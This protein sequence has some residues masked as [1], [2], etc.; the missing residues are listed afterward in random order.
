[1]THIDTIAFFLASNTMIRTLFLW[2]FC[3]TSLLAQSIAVPVGDSTVM[4]NYHPGKGPMYV[5]LHENETTALLAIKKIAPVNN[6][7]WLSLHHKGTR[8]ISFSIAGRAYQFDPNRMFS[9]KGIRA[10]LEQYGGYSKQAAA[11]VN[12]LASKVKSLIGKNAVI[13]VHNNQGYSFRDYL[14]GHSSA[15]DAKYLNFPLKSH[16]RNFL[17]MTRHQD[18]CRIIKNRENAIEQRSSVHDDG[19]LSV[20][21]ARRAYINV[22]AGYNQL[23]AQYRMLEKAQKILS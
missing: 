17:L 8:N 14:P 3:C 20:Y 16:Y 10:S 18:Y 23:A 5:H 6:N 1:M 15:Q 7:S 4:I 9:A 2:I 19:S 13:A 12:G 11:A 22:E 21:M